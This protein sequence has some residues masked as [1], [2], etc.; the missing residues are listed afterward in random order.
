MQ[1]TKRYRERGDVHFL[2]LIVFV[3]LVA[4]VGFV[5]YNAWQRNSSDAATKEKQAVASAEAKVKKLETQLK[6]QETDLKKAETDLKKLN[7]DKAFEAKRVAAFK[8]FSVK[9]ATYKQYQAFAAAET[10]YDTAV[11]NKA[12]KKTI[13]ATKADMDKKRAAW[14]KI[15]DGL[16]EFKNYQKVIAPRTNLENKVSDLKK[17]ITATKNSIKDAKSAVTKAQKTLAD[18]TKNEKIVAQCKSKG[19]TWHTGKG[20]FKQTSRSGNDLT[21]AKCSSWGG[22]YKETW[23]NW[24]SNGSVRAGSAIPKNTDSRQHRAVQGRG[25]AGFTMIETRTLQKKT[26][27]NY[28]QAI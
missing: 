8:P 25:V 16:T 27:S 21:K 15:R 12:A 28:W 14:V 22:T 2:L 18:V 17:K 26:C 23:S 19:G 1:T 11:K 20:C 24:S 10:A 9:R 5:G 4:A 3:A 6:T 13:D 7:A